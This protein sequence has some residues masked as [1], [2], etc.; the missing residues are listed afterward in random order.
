M[1]ALPM[2]ARRGLF[3]LA[4]ATALTGVALGA[5]VA[6]PP[7]TPLVALSRRLN[8]LWDRHH[9]LDVEALRSSGA[10][11]AAAQATMDAT[12]TEVLD[13]QASASEHQARS[14]EDVAIQ[15]AITYAYVDGIAASTEDH[16]IEKKKCLTFLASMIVFLT[17]HGGIDIES[18]NGRGLKNLCALRAPGGR[19]AA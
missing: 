17:D 3:G 8:N 16:E 11:K 15:A 4:A 18:L 12:L 10:A 7:E 6:A 13:L 1:N 9:A 19:L 14:L 5:S 2:T